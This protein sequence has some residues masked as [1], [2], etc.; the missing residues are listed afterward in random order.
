MPDS[1]TMTEAQAK[2]LQIEVRNDLSQDLD[3]YVIR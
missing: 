1:K 3:L 2:D